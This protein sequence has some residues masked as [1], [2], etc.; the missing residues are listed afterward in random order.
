MVPILASLSNRSPSTIE[1]DDGSGC[2]QLSRNKVKQ[3]AGQTLID[4]QDFGSGPS[5]E[6]LLRLSDFRHPI[7]QQSS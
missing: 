3:V 2:Q 7:N 5:T 6:M 1:T 4:D